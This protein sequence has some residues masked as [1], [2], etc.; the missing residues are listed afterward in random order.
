MELEPD[1]IF[2]DEKIVVVN[3]PA[4]MIVYPDGK[5]DYP[6][7]SHW[8]EKRYPSKDPEQPNYHFVH[9]IDRETSGVL[10]VAKDEKTHQFL[11]EQ[12]QDRE[13]QK[14]YRAFVMGNL[15]DERGMINKPIG[16]S[17]G[18][19]GPR[20]AKQPKGTTREALTI[21]K[22][23]ERSPESTGISSRVTYVEVY[24]KTGRT[25]Q[26][27][28]HFSAIGHPI[29]ADVLYG[30]KGGSKL[31]GFERLALHAL[32]IQITHPNGKIMSFSAPLPADF[33][34]AEGELRKG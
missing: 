9:R 26:I 6:A 22:T 19:S 16:S 15:K 2:E 17:R 21:Y 32:S 4:G 24:P 14:T 18:G 28:V 8:L 7:L 33:V 1:I 29:V 34:A 11:K 13:I 3:K 31:L 30:A 10:V 5:H 27:R 25:H 23:L 20:S 12:F